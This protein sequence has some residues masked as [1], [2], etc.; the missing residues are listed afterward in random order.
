MYTA[1]PAWKLRSL[2]EKKNSAHTTYNTQSYKSLLSYI[3]FLYQVD[4]PVVP[5]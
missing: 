1:G 4:L 2:I 5:Q 3:Y